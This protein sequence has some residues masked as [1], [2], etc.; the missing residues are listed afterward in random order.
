[1]TPLD[2]ASQILDSM[3]GYLG[4]AVKI[5]QDEGPEGPTLMIHSEDDSQRL[6]GK[7]GATLEDIQYLVNRVLQRHLP[8]APRIRVDIDYYRSMREDQMVDHA[9][10]L[11]ERVRAT[12]KS[13]ILPPMNSY[14]RRIIHNVFVND[15][16]V[17]SVSLDA[18]AR[19]KRIQ[20][21]RR[22]S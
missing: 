18:Q 22:R 19:F 4:F 9:R 12:G 15:P 13:E 17:Q 7:R 6:I 16:E 2:H 1:M 14:Y 11:G 21:K 5:D 3:L 10:E 20:L 8:N